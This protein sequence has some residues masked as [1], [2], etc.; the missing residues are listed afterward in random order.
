M[1]KAED[2]LH[3]VGALEEVRRGSKLVEV[4][5][6]TGSPIKVVIQFSRMCREWDVI[7][8]EVMGQE[9]KYSHSKT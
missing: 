2:S 4:K 7:R 3:K 6:E 9:L 1:R 5:K 8:T